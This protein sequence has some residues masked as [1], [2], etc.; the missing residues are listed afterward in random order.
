M[1]MRM[2]IGGAAVCG[3]C[4]AFAET[5]QVE[6]ACATSGVCSVNTVFSPDR[7]SAVAIDV[8][9]EPSWSLGS[10]NAAA[11]VVIS[12][13][14]HPDTTL[15]ATSVVRRCEAGAS[16]TFQI[17]SE[18]LETFRLLHAVEVNGTPKG[19][20]LACD[21]AFGVQSPD[22]AAWVADSRTN[23]LQCVADAGE[24]APLVYSTDWVTNG[25]P[26]TVVLTKTCDRYRRD[27]LQ[28]SVTTELCRVSA[29]ADG[30][31]DFLPKKEQGGTFTLRCSFLD[32]SGNPL[33]D[34]LTAFYRFKEQWGMALFIR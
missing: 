23:S 2:L 32:A 24:V 28:E 11:Q 34:E 13:V 15:A 27:V 10:D 20:T 4:L 22:S 14:V 5:P 29:P 19:E 6:S 30:V 12:K 33:P 1:N 8:G 16:G 9:Y 26:A 3:T 25:A 31:F 21:I 18:G 7:K 17:A